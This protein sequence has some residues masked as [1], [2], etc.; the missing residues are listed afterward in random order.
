MKGLG[1]FIIVSLLIIVSNI[2]AAGLVVYPVNSINYCQL[3]I[4]KGN[5]Q[6][7]TDKIGFSFDSTGEKSCQ[8]QPTSKW[9]EAMNTRRLLT[10]TAS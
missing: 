10:R 1:L 6:L 9:L 2:Y 8:I 7:D 5:V 3:G 4:N